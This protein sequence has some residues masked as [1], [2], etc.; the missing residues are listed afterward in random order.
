MTFHEVWEGFGYLGA[1]LGVVMVVPQI[2]R[3]VRHPSLPGV[4]TSSWALT[5]LTCLAWL[6]YGIRTKAAPQIPGNVLLVMG[7]VAVVLLVANG[8]PRQ[9]R[10]LGL[11][12]AAAA[13]LTVVSIMPAEDVGYFAF[14]LGLCSTWPQ[15][16]D[17]I[18]SWRA[19]LSSG[20][21][22]STWNLR[23]GSQICWLTY[24]IGTADLAVG[25]A[26]AV[27]LS[28]AVAMVALETS[29]RAAAP[30]ERSGVTVAA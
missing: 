19:H 8:M 6:V 16:F 28:T 20:V 25:I 22:V 14:A 18:N 11:G 2:V 4:S 13:L 26:A 30:S 15:L 9:R 27:T 7:A 29:A 17:S 5:S 24:A 3:I 21:S 12:G 1:A 23:V 10:A